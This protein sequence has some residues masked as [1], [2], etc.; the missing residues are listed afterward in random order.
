MSRYIEIE[1]ICIVGPTNHGYSFSTKYLTKKNGYKRVF[2]KC[3]KGAMMWDKL[4]DLKFSIVKE[5]RVPGYL[6]Q[7]YPT[8]PDSNEKVLSDIPVT[9][10]WI[11]KQY[12]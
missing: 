1:K 6:N 11:K 2:E 10:E 12:E 7:S 5:R 8:P 9:L 3:L 4:E